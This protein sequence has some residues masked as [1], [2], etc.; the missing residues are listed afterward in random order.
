MYAIADHSAR[1]WKRKSA[2]TYKFFKL[3][4]FILFSIRVRVVVRVPRYRNWSRNTP[5]R[6][7]GRLSLLSPSASL[8]LSL[9]SSFS[10]ILQ[11]FLSRHSRLL[12][13]FVLRSS[14]GSSF[15][16]SVKN[17]YTFLVSPN[18]QVERGV[19]RVGLLLSFFFLTRA[20]VSPSVP[21]SLPRS[22]PWQN[23]RQRLSFK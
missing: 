15:L 6:S 2:E 1:P 9:S 8:A 19:R 11:F 16:P 10:T 5:V 20:A 21:P 7:V 17:L 4:N 12:F 22:F 18:G 23:A 13:P 14:P 3:R